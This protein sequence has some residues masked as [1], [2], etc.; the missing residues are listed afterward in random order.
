MKTQALPKIKPRFFYGWIIVAVCFLADL[1][2]SLKGG[3][4]LTVLM[5]PMT[6]E[7]GW[8]RTALVGANFVASISASLAS[9]ILGRIVQRYGVRPTMVISGIISGIS[10]MPIAWVKDLWVYYLVFGLVNGL[11]R[12]LIQT[13]GVSVAVANWFVKRR[14][15]ATAIVSLGIPMAGVIGIP[16]TQFIVS[17][18]GWRSAWVVLGIFMIVLVVVPTWIFMRERPED[19]GLVPDGADGDGHIQGRRTVTS[20]ARWWGR[21]QTTYDWEGH[22]V[23]RTRAFWVLAI[24]PSLIAL[25]GPTMAT[26]IV[27]FWLDKG[28]S[29]AAAAAAASSFVLGTF[30]GRFF[31]A[32]VSSKLHIQY[33]YVVMG[34]IAVTGT[35]A[36]LLAPTFQVAYAATMFFGL[37]GGGMMQLRLQV[38]PDYFGR[39]AIAVIRGYSGPFELLGMALGPLF[40]AWVF[41]NTGS[42]NP[43]LVLYAFLSLGST[44]AILFLGKPPAA[45]KSLEGRPVAIQSP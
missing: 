1:G 23:I 39:K 17:N 12:P 15:V 10:M 33:C 30:S 4:A 13:L 34:I 5:V 31:W 20:P 42:Y 29:P 9:P 44:L 37:A 14:P 36:I 7:L 38:W 22:E 3:Y 16:L 25:T 18:W 11:S 24:V 32:A 40:A 43:A 28:L 35:T 6:L 41:D 21:Y 8:S 45:P 26:H 2:G 27:A 19:M